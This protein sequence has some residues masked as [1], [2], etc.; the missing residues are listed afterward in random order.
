MLVFGAKHSLSAAETRLTFSLPELRVSGMCNTCCVD[1]L[2]ATRV[3][4]K[5]FQVKRCLATFCPN[6]TWP[7]RC[8]IAVE[9]QL[10]A[11]HCAVQNGK[12]FEQSPTASGRA[13]S[14]QFEY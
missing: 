1:R 8:V 2:L 4:G 10:H 11:V 3:R 9:A 7:V 14:K 5:A 13:V 6:W 12:K